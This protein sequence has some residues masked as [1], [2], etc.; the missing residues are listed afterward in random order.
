MRSC[1]SR[2]VA[3]K[4]RLDRC[5]RVAEP[6]TIASHLLGQVRSVAGST[7]GVSGGDVGGASNVTVRAR[8]CRD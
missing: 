8:M 6:T 3:R 2:P 4:S 5:E 7:S 1:R